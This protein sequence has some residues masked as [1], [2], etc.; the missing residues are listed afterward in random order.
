MAEVS[1]IARPYAKAAFECAAQSKEL[2]E[3]SSMLALASIISQ[4]DKVKL[5]LDNPSQGHAAKADTFIE[6]CGDALSGSAKNF[7]RVLA[8]HKRL[9]ALAA[10][11]LDFETLKASLEQS[12]DVEV[13]SAFE[14]SDGQQEKLKSA[15]RGRWKKN[16]NLQSK[17][18]PSLI[19]GVVIRAGDMVIDGSIRGK[20]SQLAE[21]I[22][23]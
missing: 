22:N 6:L 5:L 8:E 10:I 4:T 1:T 11:A 2:T 13:A 9:S 21:S 14:L 17:V 12:V 7:I 23:S 19:G 16:I 15:L 20:L 18:D 3:W